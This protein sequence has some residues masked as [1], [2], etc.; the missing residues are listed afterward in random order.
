[1]KSVAYG[2][3]PS[4]I[5][6]E[7]MGRRIQF[8]DVQWS[9][10]GKT[11]LWL[12]NR[13][14]QGLMVAKPQGEA[15]RDLFSQFSARGGVGYGG[16]EFNAGQNAVLF[17]EKG[18][19]IF[20]F[21]LPYGGARAITPDFGSVGA[22]LFSP[23]QR[24]LLYVFSDGQNDCLALTDAEGRDWPVK[25]ASGADFY[26]QPAWSPDSQWIAWAEWNHPFMPWQASRI[27]LGKLDGAYPRLVQQAVI[28]GAQGGICTQPSFSP[29]GRW[30]AYI[31]DDGEWE[32]LVLVNLSNHQQT[33]LL[34]G[35]KLLL[36]PPVWVQ[37]VRT[38][39]WKPD[40]AGLYVIKN[41]AGISTL[42]EVNLGGEVIPLNCDPYTQLTQISVNPVNGELALIAS[43]PRHPERILHGGRAGWQA[44]AYND[45]WM[46]DPQVFS[47][48][49]PVEWRG[50][51]GKSVHGIYYPPCLPGQ[52]ARGKP[53]LI[54]SAHGGPTS[55]FE[56]R[57]P[58]ESAFFTTRGYAWLE[59]NYRGSS[60]YGKT[61]Q[62]ALDGRWGEL[63]TA[64]VISGAQAMID[65]GLADSDRLVIYGG[66]A[67]G[68][69]VLNALIHAP[70]LFKVGVA[71]YPVS[72]LVSISLDTHKFEAHYNDSLVGILPD[73]M[74]IYRQRSP[75]NFADRI[76]DTLMIFQGAEDKAVPPAQT[77]TIVARLKENGVPVTYTEYAG[78][79]HGFR[80]PENVADHFRKVERFLIEHLIL[81]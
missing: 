27:V 8:A 64:D 16:G 74:E 49:E 54:I 4:P 43:S 17:C 41:Y 12:E 13:G 55:A 63:D 60:G 9:M 19:Q 52:T 50:A 79:G 1:M 5:S 34:R 76:A 57:F 25:L 22:P 71:N 26:M 45:A 53:P 20:R 51:D 31:A 21:D 62:E 68:F 40:S 37:G 24:R 32:K 35:E 73:A 69:T 11:L 66:S 10:D 7:L 29:Y 77:Q 70:G 42:L 44:E 2:L 33:V 38:L 15:R 58:R 56:F 81:S 59:V 23:D 65:Q 3:W 18:R 75:L 39:A 80:N 67:G 6:P 30:L 61:Y 48:P 78:E 28:A 46:L 36:R 72:D 14:G 47:A